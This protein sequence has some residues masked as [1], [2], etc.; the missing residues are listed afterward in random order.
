[1]SV[2]LLRWTLGSSLCSALAATIGTG[3]LATQSLKFV[4]ITIVIYWISLGIVEWKLL[5][6]HISKAYQ[7]GLLTIVGGIVCSCLVGLLSVLILSFVLR[8][9]SPVDFGWE[10]S[11][12]SIFVSLL[13]SI[14]C[15]FAIGFLL[16][17][18]QNLILQKSLLQSNIG[19]H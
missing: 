2:F 4:P 9:F 19:Y 8:G 15:L 13:A 14:I 5:S 18:G 11:P 7:W 10:P 6:R 17:Y 1:M 12:G 3:S 16:G